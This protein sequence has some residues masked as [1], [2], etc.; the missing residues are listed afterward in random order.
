MGECAPPAAAAEP[1][2]AKTSVW[3]DID[4]CA[5][6]RGRCD[7]HR[8]AHN[9]I[10][11]LAAAGYVGPVSIAAYGDAARV[12]LPVLAAL[13]ATGICLNHVPAGSK[14][15]SE[16]RMLVDMLFWAFDNPPPGNYLLISG[17]QDLS[18]LLHRL[19]MKR[20]DV[21]LVR[22]PN[23]SSLALAAAAKKVWLWESLTAGELLLPEPPPAR[24]VLGCKLN[25]DS[26][27]T[28][29]Y[30]Q[31]KVCS[32][33]GMG[34]GNRKA[35]S[36]IRVKSL[37]KYVKKASSSST[38]AT[39]QD[40]AGP[41]GEV[42]GSSTGSTSSVLDHSSVS[43]LSSSGSESLEVA[44]E[45]ISVLLETPTLSK[46]SSQKSVLSTH[47]QQVEATHWSVPGEKSSM[48]TERVPRNAPLDLGA[49]NG[50]YNKM[51]QHLRYSDEAQTNLHLEFTTGGNK[52]KAINRPG[53]KPLRKYVKKTD[54]T[55][56]SANKQVGSAGIHDCPIGNSTLALDQASASSSSVSTLSHSSAQKLV[57]AAH[58]HQVK[59]PHEFIFVKKPSTS[60]EHGSRN[61]T[62]DSDVSATNKHPADQQAPSSEAHLHQVKA[63]H[64]SIFGK[65]PS[66]SV[67]HGSSN[68]THDSDVSATNKHPADQQP[69]SSEAQNKFHSCSNMVDSSGKLGNEHKVNKNQTYVKWINVSSASASNE[70]NPSSG[71]LDNSK[72]HTSL[73]ASSSSKS[74]ESSKVKDS[75]PLLSA[76]KPLTNDNSHQDGVLSIF[77]KKTSIS[78]QCTAK[79]EPFA[80]DVS[81]GEY[82]LTHQQA[83]SYSPPEKHNSGTHPHVAHGH[84]HSI[85][86]HRGSSASPSVAH[87][88]VSSAQIQTWSSCS[89][90]EGLDDICNGFSRLN[91]SK[92]PRG[93][94]EAS[95]PFQSLPAND[96][97]TGMAGF[98]ERRSSFHL[99]SNSSSYLNHSGD[100]QSG[101]PPS[102]N[103]T[104]RAGHLSNLSTDLQNPIHSGD[105]PGYPP[106]SAEPEGAIGIILHALGILRSE[107]IFPTESNIADCICYGEMNLTGFDVKKALEL[108]IRHEAIVM[109][110]LLHDVPLFVAKDESLWKCVNVTNSKA[111]NPIE[112][113]ETVRK[114][115]SST[116]GRSAVM[117]S[118]SRY[119]AAVI[120]KRCCLQQYALGDI[121][122]ILHIIIVR[123]KWIVP[124][125][126]GWQPLSLNTT[127]I[128]SS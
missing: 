39:N 30:S 109:K 13:S 8:I 48:V 56:S 98:H 95:P 65:K 128:I 126:S 86:S 11:A 82:N 12:P 15:T 58:L 32:E 75:S 119:Q 42:S 5:V 72:R 29:K 113:L 110:K 62:H 96:P 40:R 4:K 69:P 70:I 7:P 71:L 101:Q 23:A 90:F 103:Y 27:D 92:C 127:V 22:P 83:Q 112:E 88:G 37:Q 25:V 118:Q 36:Q 1:T 85:N 6:P 99:D 81:S 46:L 115:I 10:A 94:T 20:Y 64:E 31:N 43:S 89:T 45:N 51:Y 107:K 16:K 123:K 21:L 84:S 60:V 104:F 3:W 33:Y 47:S 59:A 18:D 2:T 87:N 24:S 102:S 50:H 124:H 78:F 53:V 67:E 122:Q 77:G 55:F 44:K 49:N 38:P 76:C 117:N 79:N 34:D 28:L 68:G 74:L 35:C 61:G 54:N 80:F 52:G 57:A 66:T 105:K 111:K 41:A 93:T 120:L 73:P 100:P 9:L 121:L 91:I 116:D 14:D 114:Y 97:S 108:A 19:R 26:S 17:D 125:S 106:K 63:P